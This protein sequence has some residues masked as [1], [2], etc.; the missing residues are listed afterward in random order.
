IQTWWVYG[1]MVLSFA[2]LAVA[3]LYGILENLGKLKS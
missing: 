1:P 3:T 2:L